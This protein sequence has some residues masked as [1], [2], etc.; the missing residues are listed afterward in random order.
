[1]CGVMFVDGYVWGRGKGLVTVVRMF[2][3]L[4]MCGICVCMPGLRCVGV[5][6]MSFM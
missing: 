5:G 2:V 1:M 6:V 3:V 4:C